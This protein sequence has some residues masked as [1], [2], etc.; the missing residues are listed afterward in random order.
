MA[1]TVKAADEEQSTTYADSPGEVYGYAFGPGG[2][3]L[4]VGGP[5]G[6]PSDA[7]VDAAWSPSAWVRVEG[8]VFDDGTVRQLGLLPS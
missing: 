4:V 2:V 5:K 3:L 6:R 8:D 7:A 1:V